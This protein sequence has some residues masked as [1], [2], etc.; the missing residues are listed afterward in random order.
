MLASQDST[1]MDVV[2]KAY[3]QILQ[4]KV[5]ESKDALRHENTIALKD[6]DAKIA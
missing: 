6:H 4:K 5:F 1:L 3:D 2:V